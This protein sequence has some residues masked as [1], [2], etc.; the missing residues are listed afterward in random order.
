[1]RTGAR[2]RMALETERGTIFDRDALQGSIEKRFMGYL[3]LFRQRFSVDRKT[4]ILAR[5]DHLTAALVQD[6]MVRAMMAKFHFRGFAVDAEF[7][8]VVGDASTRSAE[9]KR[10]PDNG[11]EADGLLLFEMN[12]VAFEASADDR[13]TRGFISIT[14]SRPSSGLTANWTFEPPVSTPIFR[15]T[16][17][18]ASRMR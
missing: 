5:N 6:R 14:R 13:D 9:G 16:S 1:M 7:F 18:D 4:V 11:W 2:L 3:G 17:M 15:S 12:P 8:C 10:W